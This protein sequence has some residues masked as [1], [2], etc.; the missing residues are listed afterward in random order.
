MGC[1]EPKVGMQAS[2][3]FPLV[4]KSGRVYVLANQF[5]GKV[6]Y[7][8]QMTG[9][10]DAVSIMANMCRDDVKIIVGGM[11]FLQS[12]PVG[13]DYTIMVTRDDDSLRAN[14][15]RRSIL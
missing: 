12:L 11:P 4:S 7:H 15:V 13:K 14:A 8:H 1:P 6:D 10:M 9:T 3:G 2:W 5:T